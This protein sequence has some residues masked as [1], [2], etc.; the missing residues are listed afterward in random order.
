MF[1]FSPTEE[2]YIKA[3]YHLQSAGEAVNTNDLAATLQTKPSSITDMLKKLKKKK[4]VNYKA[5]YGCKLTPEGNHKALAIIRRH[6]LWEY[7]L[8]QNLG[9]SWDE[10]H[11]VAEELEHV[12]S[13]KLIN[14]LDTYLGHPRFDPHG[15]P[16]P[17]PDGKITMQQQ[18]TLA[19]WEENKVATVTQ[20][21]KQSAPILDIL[22]QK[23]IAIGSTIRIKQKFDFDLSMEV[24][25]DEK[26]PAHITKELAQNI[27]V[28]KHE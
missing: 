20:I 19:E 2:N 4:L 11:E 18:K 6:R 28:T 26:H 17:D 14:K 15:D 13:E 16:I 8:S 21:G 22:K 1:N 25:I 23:K 12:S 3:I 27:F 9:F 24:R 10:V 5:Y 7:F